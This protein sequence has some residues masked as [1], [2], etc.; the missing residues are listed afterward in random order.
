MHSAA[1][2]VISPCH[3]TISC[4]SSRATRTAN[5][6]RKFEIECTLLPPVVRGRGRR[7]HVGRPGPAAGCLLTAELR[8]PSGAGG[9]LLDHVG[10]RRSPG[11]AGPA[12]S[13]GLPCG[14]V[15]R[16][17]SFRGPLLTKRRPLSYGRD[18]VTAPVGGRR[19][20]SPL[21]PGFSGTRGSGMIFGFDTAAVLDEGLGAWAFVRRLVE[22]WTRPLS[23]GDG[24]SEADL[25]TAEGLLGGRL[26]SALRTVYGL[27]GKRF[28]LTRCRD[29]LLTPYQCHWDDTGEVL[30]FRAE[31]QGCAQSGG[32]RGRGNCCGRRPAGFS[33]GDRPPRTGVPCAPPFR[34]TGRWR[35]TPSTLLRLTSMTSQSSLRNSASSHALCGGA[36]RAMYRAGE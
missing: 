4:L 14:R 22:G 15:R 19:P 31:N 9:R 10:A 13:P 25:V 28:D 34:D 26:P 29:D 16:H 24:W 35:T 5:S 8:K 12:A 36:S 33:Y 32:T 23:P 21:S 30:V 6:D 3:W 2:G 17:P 27:L 20:L 11:G 18:P 1:P 7:R